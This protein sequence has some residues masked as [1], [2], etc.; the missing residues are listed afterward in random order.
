MNDSIGPFVIDINHLSFI[1]RYRLDPSDSM[2]SPVRCICFLRHVLLC[3]FN[4]EAPAFKSCPNLLR[5]SVIGLQ[6]CF[7]GVFKKLSLRNQ[8]RMRTDVSF[9]LPVM[10]FV[11]G[12]NVQGFAGDIGISAVLLDQNELRQDAQ[13]VHLCSRPD[14][15]QIISLIVRGGI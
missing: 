12:V 4:Q 1:I 14:L 7:R 10:L 15:P 2:V 6:Q 13:N 8:R 9:F 3:H 11:I 5:D